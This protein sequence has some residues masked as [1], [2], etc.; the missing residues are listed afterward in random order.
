MRKY[1]LVI[2][3]DLKICREIRAVLQ[4][5]NIEVF[6]SSSVRNAWNIFTKDSLYLVIVD[7]QLN[8]VNGCEL[9]RMIRGA[10]A[11]PVLALYSKDGL[12]SK[13]DLFHAGADACLE[14]SS[15]LDDIVAQARALIRLYSIT[16]VTES[17]C[18][19]LPFGTELII[20]PTCWQVTMGGK[21]IE[22][23]RKEFA[24]LYCLASHAGQALT[25]EQLYDQVWNGDED[26]NLEATI[27][28]HIRSL[29][30]KLG[31]GSKNFIENVW[32]VGYRFSIKAVPEK[33]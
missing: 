20:D 1:V 25:K 2:G 23:T 27:K 13:S 5:N 16:P 4:D 6:C 28:S 11:I 3:S 30:Q 9:V 18:H 21:Q 29:R 24:L 33:K 14:I 26:I 32:G 17:K 22:L 8:D 15:D 12:T 7:A 31:P 10:K 19:V